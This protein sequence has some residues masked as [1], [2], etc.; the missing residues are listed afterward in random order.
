MKRYEIY[1]ADLNPTI[2]SEIRKVGPVVII[3][4]H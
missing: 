2:G 3:S 1:Y 4:A